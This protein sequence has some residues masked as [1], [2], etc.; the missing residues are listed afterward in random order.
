MDL[1][2]LKPGDPVLY[3][4][5]PGLNDPVKCTFIGQ[6]YSAGHKI[7]LVSDD[8][9]HQTYYAPPSKIKLSQELSRVL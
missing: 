9:S 3:D 7:A 6:S 2:Q 8:E 4:R 5:F 1:S